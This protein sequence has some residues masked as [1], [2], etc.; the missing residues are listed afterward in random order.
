MEG[1]GEL[2]NKRHEYAI[3]WKEKKKGKV[4][5]YFCTYVPEEIIYAAGILP[6]RIIGSHE[7]N[8]GT[9]KHITNMYC[10]FC[11]DCLSQALKGRYPYLNGIVKARSCQQMRQVFASWQ[12]HLP[13]EYNYYIKMPALIQSPLARTFLIKEFLSFKKSLEEW[14]GNQI[15]DE[16]LKQAIETYNTNR[17]FLR[18]VYELRKEAEPVI[19]GAE[20]LEM[21]LSSQLVDK[22]EHN[23]LLTKA[24]KSL[25]QDNQHHNT[26]VRLMLIGSEN[27]DIDYVN[28][29][30]SLGSVIVID[31]SC[32][33]TRYFW[34]E[35]GSEADPLAALASRY[36][37]RPPCPAKDLPEHRRGPHI[38]KLI[39]DY[40]VEGV[41]LTLQRFCHNHESDIPYLQELLREHNV[42]FL[43]LEYSFIAPKNWYQ[44]RIEAFLEMIRSEAIWV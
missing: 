7:S 40:H 34:N 20:A 38:L 8:V 23:Q 6:V 41:I 43:Q 33:G 10:S 3:N 36:I 14:T 12:I 24:L 2:V 21:S 31:E 27:D 9:E 22:A 5:G 35:T 13:I 37:D 28:L 18:Q 1:F 30:E 17:R 19:S 15:S 42:P 29:I 32:T 25:S 39:E 44:N 4:L 11:R 26:G 16:A